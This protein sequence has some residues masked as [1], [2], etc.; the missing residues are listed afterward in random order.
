MATFPP[1][2]KR[3]VLAALQAELGTRLQREPGVSA[4]FRSSDGRVGVAITYSQRHS[5]GLYWFGYYARWGEFLRGLSQAYLVLCL[6]GTD[7]YLLI[8]SSHV[9]SWSSHLPRRQG[10]RGWAHVVI[11]ELPGGA[12]RLQSLPDVSLDRYE[13]RLPPAA[14]APTGPGTRAEGGPAEEGPKRE[15]RAGGRSGGEA[16]PE[17]GSRRTSP[18]E[19]RAAGHVPEVSSIDIVDETGKVVA[20]LSA[21]RG[22]L[23]LELRGQLEGDDR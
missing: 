6:G 1:D 4:L 19:A 3:R 17:E 21:R 16:L 10:P 22:R 2:L 9:D 14:T 11:R 18:A 8:P 15:A 13:R 20:T 5:D 23:V 12:L 7:R